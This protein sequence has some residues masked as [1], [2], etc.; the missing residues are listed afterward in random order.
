M[1][2]VKIEGAT[3]IDGTGA[4]GGRADVGVR[5]DTIV[6]VGDLSRELAGRTLNAA[7]RVVAPGFIDMHSHSDWR[8]WVNRR[9]ESKIRQGVTLEVVGNC[10]FSPA[11]VSTEHLADMRGFALYLPPGL[12]FRWRSVGEY[13]DAFDAQG[14]A[15]NVIQLVG[16]GALRVAAMGFA[17]RPPTAEELTGMQR[18]LE[19]GLRAGAWG[20]S[21]GLIYAPGSYATT[22]EIV[23]LARTAARGRSFYASHIRGEGATLL[24]A[25]TEAIR[26][27]RESGLPV[28]VSHVKAAGRPNWGGVADA[29][30]LIDAA[31]G[32]GLDVQA[33]VYPY[34]ASST[35]LRALLPDWA[36][37]GGIDAM[38]GRLGDAAVRARVR[39][40]LET[41]GTGQPLGE[42]IGW[43]NIMVAS[44]P[45]RRDAEGKRLATIAL[46][47][48]MDPLDAA[49]ELIVDGAG[50]ATIVLFQ[51]DEGDLRRALAHPRVMI[52][53]DGSALAPYGE[54]GE[55]KPHPR[56][57]GTF[58]RVLGEYAR[59]QRVL[60][61]AQAVHKMTGLPARRLG[62]RDRGV[63][64][65]G[66]KADLVIFDPKRVADQATYEDPH[67]YPVGIEHVLVN[68]H[69]VIKDGEHTGSLPGRLLRLP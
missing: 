2:D 15:L 30:A 20:L 7:G 56:S 12:D 35:T 54:L 1:L 3:V 43:E 62:L 17:R 18:S 47:R 63:I 24:D 53:S 46:E 37:E 49:I 22:A 9:A 26:V 45:R 39:A 68:G 48:G 61:L 38:V 58:P 36:L 13:L 33:D 65:A 52:G 11:P 21:T 51:L 40:E 60:S 41:P 32:E 57:Y 4:A 64:R 28:Q 27:G 66:A 10:G 23:A 14:T 67:Q 8:L 44:A 25:V 59:E 69:F 5:D 50:K 31:A 34:M 6:A 42:R 19:E 55:G 16:H 29:L